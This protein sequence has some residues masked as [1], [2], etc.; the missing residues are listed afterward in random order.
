M[1]LGF[2]GRLNTTPAVCLP[3]CMIRHAAGNCTLRTLVP[4]PH[5]A[6]CLRLHAACRRICDSPVPSCPALP[7]LPCL[8]RLCLTCSPEQEAAAQVREMVAEFYAAR[9]SA[10]LE[11]LHRLAPLLRL[12][13]HLAAHLP[14]LTQVGLGV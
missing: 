4:D 5:L 2:W 7:A 14:A 3:A 1:N 12:D 11:R 10:A 13:M 8:L 6:S 9:Y